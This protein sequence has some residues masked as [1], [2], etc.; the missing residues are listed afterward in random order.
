MNTT[1]NPMVGLVEIFPF[2]NDRDAKWRKISFTVPTKSA[3]FVKEILKRTKL[4][5][6]DDLQVIAQIFSE[7]TGNEEENAK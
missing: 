1:Q 7:F 5:R 4:V 2:A 3:I 6:H